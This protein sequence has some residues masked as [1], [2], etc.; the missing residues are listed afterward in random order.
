MGVTGA[1]GLHVTLHLSGQ[2]ARTN[3]TKVGLGTVT[4]RTTR[5]ALTAIGGSVLVS[6]D[7]RGRV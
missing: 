5:G 3:G 7:L 2:R 4:A 1:V 6:G